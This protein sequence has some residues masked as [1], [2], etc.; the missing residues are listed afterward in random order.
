MASSAAMI[1]PTC[2]PSPTRTRLK[3]E[4][5]LFLMLLLFGILLLPIAIYAVGDAIFGA[6]AGAGFSGFYSTLHEALRSGELMAWYLVLSPYVILQLL[7]LTLF[8]F[9]RDR[10]TPAGRPSARA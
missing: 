7:R 2:P 10:P 3:R 6:Y 5:A 1:R 8:G 4:L 9:R